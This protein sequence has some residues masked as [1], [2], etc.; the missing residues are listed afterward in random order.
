MPLG[1]ALLILSDS[2]PLDVHAWQIWVKEDT[3]RHIKFSKSGIPNY[4][5]KV[6]EKFNQKQTKKMSIAKS[7]P[8]QER[9]KIE[10]QT[11]SFQNIKN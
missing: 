1:F 8:L 4:N 6:D 11:C 7:C 5:F 9:A 10:L 3:H 2:S